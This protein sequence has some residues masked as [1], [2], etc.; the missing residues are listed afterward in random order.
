MATTATRTNYWFIKT[1]STTS[2]AFNFKFVIEVHIGGSKKATLVQPKNNAG[3]AHFDLER[4]VKNYIKITNLKNLQSTTVGT[5]YEDIH[6]IPRN[7]TKPAGTQNDRAVSRS[8]NNFITVTLKYFED[9]ATS[10]G[11]TITR[12][13]SAA[14]QNIRILNIANDWHDLKTFD[15]TPFIFSGAMVYPNGKFLTKL[16]TRDKNNNFLEHH[17]GDNDFRTF[18]ALNSFNLGGES[19]TMEYSF[20]EEM[21]NTTLLNFRATTKIS[22]PDAAF[23]GDLDDSKSLIYV[24]AG[25][26]NV[27]NVKNSDYGGAQLLSTDK[28]YTV[29]ATK[30]VAVAVASLSAGLIKQGM[31]CII[32]FVGT[33]D[34]VALGAASNTAGI[35]FFASSSPGGF[36]GTG[37]VTLYQY[38]KK[39]DIHLF[40][41]NS[42]CNK[43]TSNKTTRTICWKN[44]YGVW[45]YYLFDTK[46]SERDNTKRSIQYTKNAGTY[47][48][49]NYNINSFERGKVQKVSGV[50]SFKASTRFVDESYNDYFRGLIMSNDVKMIIKKEVIEGQLDGENIQNE[51]VLPLIMTSNSISYK[52]VLNDDLI[53]YNFD[54]E[55]AHDLKEQV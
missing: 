36:I 55:L 48:S 18:A 15:I 40:K 49:A 50:H 20:Y 45:D 30:T 12:N 35:G 43:F 26:E 2:P 14:D 16:A 44:K 38:Q 46:I 24:A 41:I 39:T 31:F 25:Y 3:S 23:Q 29:C 5:A 21:P 34:F 9:Y 52:T 22:D 10:A 32:T 54:F 19:W 33:T 6:L 28:Y 27:K 7:L 53:Q 42:D 17:S 37:I 51:Y 13:S 47:N 8:A 4:V 11:G 1:T